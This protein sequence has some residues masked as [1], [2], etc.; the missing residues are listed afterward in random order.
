MK[1]SEDINMLTMTYLPICPTEPRKWLL[2]SPET[3]PLE[4]LY[5]F[6]INLTAQFHKSHVMRDTKTPFKQSSSLSLIPPSPD[7]LT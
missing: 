1:I 7:D 3:L 4:A 2:G 6:A 5:H